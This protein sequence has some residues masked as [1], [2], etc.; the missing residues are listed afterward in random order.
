MTHGAH[1]SPSS[2]RKIYRAAKQRREIHSEEAS[3]ATEKQ[4]D[5][6]DAYVH[7][8]RFDEALKCMLYIKLL[9]Y[10]SPWASVIGSRD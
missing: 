9:F 4:L 7:C 1:T 6:C 8:I 2:E 10:T 5:L 3:R